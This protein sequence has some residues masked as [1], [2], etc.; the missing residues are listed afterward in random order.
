MAAWGLILTRITTL[1]LSSYGQEYGFLEAYYSILA[2]DLTRSLAPTWWDTPIHNTPPLYVWLLSAWGHVLGWSEMSLRLPSTIAWALAAIPIQRLGGRLA[3]LAWLSFPL[4]FILAG[5]VMPDM[6]VASLCSWAVLMASRR[7]LAPFLGLLVAACGMKPIAGVIAVYPF[8]T[9]WWTGAAYTTLAGTAGIAILG[10]VRGYVEM[11]LYHF[12]SRWPGYW[13]LE[14]VF[15]VGLGQGTIL[16]LWPILSHRKH[17]HLWGLLL[18]IIIIVLYAMPDWGYHEYYFLLALP[19]LAILTGRSQPPR[20]VIA[21]CMVFLAVSLFQSG[22]LWDHRTAEMPHA[23]TA[24]EGLGTVA[25]WYAG[26]Q[27]NTSGPGVR[28]SWSPEPNCTTL[29]EYTAPVGIDRS[30]YALAC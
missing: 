25:S 26:R 22:D 29:N 13:N 19:V 4:G 1:P 24:A 12:T 10:A 11:M 5:R 30:L 27:V 18:G 7:R 9:G 15:L 21:G 6:V 14:G 8:L 23:D 20:A 3:A 16:G 17:P 2:H 28:W